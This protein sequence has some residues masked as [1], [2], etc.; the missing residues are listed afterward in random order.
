MGCLAAKACGAC[1]G[2]SRRRKVKQIWSSSGLRVRRRSNS[3]AED[4]RVSQRQ[5]GGATSI[6][7]RLAKG[8]A[9]CRP[10]GKAFVSAGTR[11]T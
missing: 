11:R 10:G 9:S 4:R 2:L 3:R 6:L 8:S 5:E 7:L 1:N